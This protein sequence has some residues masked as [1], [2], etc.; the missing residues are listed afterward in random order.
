VANGDV[1]VTLQDTVLTVA[2]PGLLANDVDPEGQPLTVTVTGQP[3]NGTLAPH[4]D[5]SFS[6]TPN[7]GFSGSDTFTYKA[8]DGALDSNEASVLIT[9]ESVEGDVFVVAVPTLS[10]SGALLMLL[11]MFAAGLIGIRRFT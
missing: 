10:R 1:Y 8:N 3:A 7:A 9:V 11:L 2:A 4:P 5:G 6:Y